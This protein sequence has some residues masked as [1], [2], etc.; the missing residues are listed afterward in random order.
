V[1][2]SVRG[3]EFMKFYDVG[4]DIISHGSLDAND[5]TIGR[6]TALQEAYDK[7]STDFNLTS[8][9]EPAGAALS[10]A[11]SWGLAVEAAERFASMAGSVSSLLP[12][13]GAL[14]IEGLSN[15]E[16]TAANH[17]DEQ[18]RGFSGGRNLDENLWNGGNP[19]YW[20]QMGVSMP[21]ERAEPTARDFYP[22]TTKK[23]GT[24]G[25]TDGASFMPAIGEEDQLWGSGA[26]ALQ[27][28]GLAATDDML[29]M[30]EQRYRDS[31][32]AFSDDHL[33][34]A[35]GNG[36]VFENG[37]RL[38]ENG[39][40][41]RISPEYR[42]ADHAANAALFGSVVDPAAQPVPALEPVGLDEGGSQ[43]GQDVFQFNTP[44]VHEKP[45]DQSKNFNVNALDA[46]HSGALGI[47][48]T[49]FDAAGI[50][51]GVL[52]PE[53]LADWGA[54]ANVDE[55]ATRKFSLGGFTG[56]PV[57][58]FDKFPQ[59]G[60]DQ[61]PA[62]GRL[63]N[64]AM[65]KA[66]PEDWVNTQLSIGPDPV[67]GTHQFQEAAADEGSDA[68]LVSGKASGER[69]INGTLAAEG[70]MFSAASLGPPPWLVALTEAVVMELV[71]SGFQNRA[72]T[73]GTSSA[74]Q[75]R[76]LSPL[77][78]SNDPVHVKVVDRA[79]SY[80]SHMPGAPTSSLPSQ[81][82]PM[83]GQVMFSP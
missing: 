23:D 83:P 29:G 25:F 51:Q 48:Q 66:A 37:Q 8:A 15:P 12:A 63:S 80:A 34:D 38:A 26:G 74:S 7:L 27:L 40:Y 58:G 81:T 43:F 47:P 10:L 32:R 57:D 60:P 4:S 31:L 42:N 70:A 3:A 52:P 82:P 39:W 5:G 75:Q 64:L 19:G 41:E 79:V 33:C 77:G 55:P 46:I 17:Q 24:N 22:E 78:T 13:H 30:A 59:F 36:F 71:S 54:V 1:Y 50:F 21:Q 67:A 45:A 65:A 11:S 56:E 6:L 62:V 44:S 18:S 72:G 53:R 49:G 2:D 73:F 76:P 28:P 14:A 9:A 68:A 61:I 16:K 69:A 35:A 20:Y